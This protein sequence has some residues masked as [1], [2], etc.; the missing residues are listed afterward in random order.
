MEATTDKLKSRAQGCLDCPICSHARA[1]QKGIA[2]LLVKHIDRKVCP[3]C[4]GFEKVTGQL[5]FEPITQELI[6]KIMK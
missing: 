1:K 5:A 3:N 2:Y 4:K 6:D